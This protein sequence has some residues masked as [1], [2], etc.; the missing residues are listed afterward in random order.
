[1]IPYYNQVFH[2]KYISVSCNVALY[3]LTTV[4]S[5][6]LSFLLF[7]QRIYTKSCRVTSEREF[8]QAKDTSTE[9]SPPI[10]NDFI[11]HMTETEF[12]TRSLNQTSF[13][14]GTFDFLLNKHSGCEKGPLCSLR[15]YTHIWGSSANRFGV[16]EETMRCAH[17]QSYQVA[18]CDH[19]CDLRSERKSQTQSL[20]F[21]IVL[22]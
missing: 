22:P 7:P 4:P 2:K 13:L 1:M 12:S 8:E 18:Q 19:L 16:E 14:S 11:Q 10:Q 9:T 5:M 20:F 15:S 17:S 3:M 6:S 21:H